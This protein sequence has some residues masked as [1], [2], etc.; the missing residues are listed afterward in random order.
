ML[1]AVSERHLSSN[2]ISLVNSVIRARLASF[3]FAA[4]L[5]VLIHSEDFIS[6]RPISDVLV[7]NGWVD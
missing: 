1:Q 4:V 6:H 7:S 3:D 2:V 5:K